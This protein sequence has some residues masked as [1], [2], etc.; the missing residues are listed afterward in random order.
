MRAF[1]SSHL[2]REAHLL[3]GEYQGIKEQSKDA[4]MTTYRIILQTTEIL[5]IKPLVPDIEYVRLSQ[6]WEIQF[7]IYRTI[8]LGN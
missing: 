8:S 4:L 2:I 7:T 5:Y 6:G 3:A 1:A